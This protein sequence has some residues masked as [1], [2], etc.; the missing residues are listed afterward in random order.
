MRTLSTDIETYSG[1]DLA[2][3][4]VYRYAESPDF[5]ILLFGYSVNGG[6]VQVVDLTAG[7]KI[8][9]KIIAALADEDVTKW[10]FNAQF[11]RIC[12]SKWLGFTTGR[13]LAP[14]SWRCT[15]I[16]SAYMGL[17]LSL[18]GTGAVLGL[19]NLK[20][21]EGKDLI[22]YFCQ[23][24]KPTV[25]NG[26][27]TRNLPTNAPDKWVAFKAYNRRD[28]EAEMAI[29]EKLAKFPVPESLWDEYHLDQEINDRGVFLDMQLVHS[30]I[31]ADALSR[32]ELI[33]LMRELTELDNPNSVIQM[34]HWLSDNGLETET[35]G[36]KAVAELLKTAPEPLGRV[37]ELRQLL[38]KS[39]VK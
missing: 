30:A 39:S 31:E 4:G 37:L 16:W 5:A 29:Q 15:M 21:K 3:S 18:E 28:V 27:R 12:L 33:N 19:E 38:A 2:K 7:E 26:Q 22:R 32:T 24:C 17:P 23:P 10:A 34:K 1:V 9:P 6:E 25:A 14:Q 11:E 8:P 13:Y 36:K 20:L 35:L